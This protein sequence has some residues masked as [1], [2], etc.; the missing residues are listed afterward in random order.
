MQLF[1]F[2]VTFTPGGG[3]CNIFIV[4]LPFYLPH[5]PHF[6]KNH[7]KSMRFFDINTMITH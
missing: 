3:K 6:H 5:L 4:K 1:Y 2:C 7:L